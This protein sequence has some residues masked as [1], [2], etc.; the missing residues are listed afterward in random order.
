MWPLLIIIIII[1][2]GLWQFYPIKFNSVWNH[3]MML[4]SLYNGNFNYL[5]DPKQSSSLRKVRSFTPHGS[6]LK[7][8]FI[9][10][11]E[12]YLAKIGI[13]IIIII[14]FLHNMNLFVIKN[15]WKQI[16]LPRLSWE[17]DGHLSLFQ[18]KWNICP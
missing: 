18:T 14:V 16:T 12:L 13:V 7:V 6:I 4:I 1:L 8:N 2:L 10:I 3:S 17:V 15:I 11:W 9:I 5:H